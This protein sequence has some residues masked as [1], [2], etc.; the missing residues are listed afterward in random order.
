MRYRPTT[1]LGVVVRFAGAA[2]I[3]F[4]ASC[5]S[6]DDDEGDGDSGAEGGVAGRGVSLGGQ[7]QGGNAGTGANAG[8]GV[9]NAP[10]PCEN[11]MAGECG[12]TSVEANFKTVNILLV[13]D[14][15]GSM[16]DTPDGFDMKKWAATK[17]ALEAALSQTAESINFGLLLYPYSL[18]A[19][20][21]LDPC[22]TRCCEV[23][24]GAQSINVP[25]GPGLE[26]V[27]DILGTLDGTSPGGG[28]PTAAA[29]A[30]AYEYFTTGEGAALQGD[31]FVLLATDG[32][33]N[34]N[35]EL[36]CDADRCTTNL[37]EQSTTPNYCAGSL[38]SRC[39]DDEAVKEQVAALAAEGINTFVVGIPG[40]EQ[41]SEYL[42]AIASV[43]G[44]P[45]TEGP[46]QYYRVDAE[47]GVQGLV[48]VFTSI[49]TQLV[50]G[51]DIELASRP[52]NPNLVNVYIDCEVVPRGEDADDPSWE[53]D[54]STDIPMIKLRGNV[55]TRVETRGAERVDVTFGCPSVR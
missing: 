44:V 11:L 30:G 34:C 53:V 29:L 40:T 12:G 41:Y 32:G 36:T 33:P 16:D 21:A 6:T 55:C 39:L 5:S 22:V 35:E 38:G 31:R 8:A 47:G 24:S 37:D 46:N 3:A 10:S 14:K 42:D 7:P 19:P 49:T 43:S 20:I 48:D 50:R 25:I 45:N 13:I 27:P 54:T 23:P 51:C 17:Q 28:T 2:A 9:G 18:V 15:S 4:A 26:T 1:F 52:Y